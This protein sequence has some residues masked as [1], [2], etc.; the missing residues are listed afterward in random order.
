[1]EWPLSYWKICHMSRAG[2]RVKRA[3][4]G[5]TGNECNSQKNIQRVLHAG[6]RADGGTFENMLPQQNAGNVENMY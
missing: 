6:K 3:K 4:R 2:K 5:K 1:M